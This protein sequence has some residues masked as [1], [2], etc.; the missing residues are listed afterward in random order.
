M[1]WDSFSC[2]KSRCKSMPGAAIAAI[3]AVTGEV[4][5]GVGG[6]VENTYSIKWDGTAKET[7]YTVSENLG[8]LQ[9]TRRPVVVTANDAGKIYGDQDPELT[10]TPGAAEGNENSGLVG[11]ETVEFT[12]SRETGENAGSYVIT[13]SGAENQGN[14]VL[15]I[16]PGIFTIVNSGENI[17]TGVNL[18]G[19]QGTTKMYD[20]TASTITATAAVSGSTFEYSLDGTTWTSEV[21]SFTNAG[22]YPVWVRANAANYD[23]TPAVRATV[24]ITPAPVTITVA[25]ATKVAG[26][27]DPVFLGAVSGLVNESDLGIVRYYR[28]N[29][30][31]AVGTYPN[32]LSATFTA[33]PNYVVSVQT[34]TFTITALP[35]PVFP[36]PTTPAT[37]GIT[38]AGPAALAGP[39][40][41]GGGPAA[42]VAINDA[43][44]P[45]AE[46]PAAEPEETIIADDAVPMAAAPEHEQE[47]WVH[48]VMIAGIVLTLIYAAAVA[49]R[50]MSFT[51]KLKGREDDFT[52]E[53]TD[54][55][56]YPETSGM[57]PT[58]G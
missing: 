24:T 1:A 2:P 43:P 56:D 30:A 22:T 3:F 34:G 52:G 42:A 32:V 18:A 36:A 49:V 45:L 54:A 31:E 37:P 23:T 11:N 15:T 26:Q 7:N 55:E 33:N 8:T 16:V 21:P 10:A 6:P 47:C 13:A 44:T 4:G 58:I 35:A 53:G 27:A 57:T 12:V 29:D 48:M 50:R 41:P 5:P 25:N 19:A 51:N 17:V 28:T 46:T 40:A 9:I 38:P 39:A 20:G 14:Y